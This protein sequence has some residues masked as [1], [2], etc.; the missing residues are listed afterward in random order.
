MKTNTAKHLRIL[1]VFMLLTLFSVPAA[2]GQLLK[3]L[4]KRAERAAERT[5]ERRVEKETTEK[6]DQVLDSILEPGSKGPDN[7]V[8]QDSPEGNPE[9]NPSGNGG[10]SPKAGGNTSGSGTGTTS[11]PKALEVYSKFDFVPGDEILF[12]DDFSDD[13]IGDFPAKWN[14]NGSGEVVSFDDGSGKWLELNPGG[15][16]YYIANLSGLP[17]DYTL[18]FDI[19][20]TGI[21]RQTS[22]TAKLIVIL[23]DNDGFGY[24]KNTAW[25]Y[26][27]F[28]Q[29]TPIGIRLWNQIEKERTI[30]NTVEA[31]LRTAMINRPHISIAVNEQRYRLYVNENKYVDVPRMIGPDSPL[32]YLKFQLTGTKDGKERVFV[33]N[34]KVAKGGEDLRRKLLAE[35]K[36]STNAILFDSG[37]ANLQPA[38][39]GVIR[40]ISQVLTQDT[41]MRLQIIGHTDSDGEQA[42]N[43]SL[44]QA[45]AEAVKQVLISVYN[46]SG[47]RLE[48]AGKGESE[49]VSDNSS[50]NGKAQNRRVE[51][52]K[53]Q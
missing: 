34:I 42:A 43:Q 29:Y 35:G 22:S 47:D 28:A 27:P 1:G 40:Q 32:N 44:S 49:P 31:D 12:F 13:F 51:F 39:M 23:D 53:I 19:E 17:N 3:K 2:H 26:L 7:P 41:G 25:S 24:G 37:S 18:E 9:G 16:T 4:G 50:A 52:I 5:I 14:T 30:S 36:I 6:T 8:P 21:D 11:G 45:R 33:S 15:S 20:S 38:S 46:V 10:E 48:T